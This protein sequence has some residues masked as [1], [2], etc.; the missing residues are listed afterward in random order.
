MPRDLAE[1]PQTLP[2]HFLSMA[3]GDSRAALEAACAT[4]EVFA[5]RASHGYSRM[6][7]L[8]RVRAPKPI[9]PAITLS[10]EEAR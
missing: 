9:Q 10:S 8:H 2:E 3:H 7:P 1:P 5:S 6:P 4:L